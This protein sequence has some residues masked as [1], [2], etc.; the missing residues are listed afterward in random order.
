[1]GGVRIARCPGGAC[2]G[3]PH[4][5]WL[6]HAPDLSVR[7][8]RADWASEY[9]IYGHPQALEDRPQ[10]APAALDGIAQLLEVA[11]RAARLGAVSG[12]D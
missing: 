1:M 2:L 6:I 11:S 4:S 10:V 3:V 12:L 9:C 5:H 7:S 8:P